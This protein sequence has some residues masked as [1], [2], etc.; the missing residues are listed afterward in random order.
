M[1]NTPKSDP[2][3]L[4]KNNPTKDG[5]Y[6]PDW[7][8][9]A[10]EAIRSQEAVADAIENHS[11]SLGLKEFYKNLPLN[12]RVKF[13]KFLTQAG[14]TWDNFIIEKGARSH[15]ALIKYSN[16]KEIAMG[17]DSISIKDSKRMIYFPGT[18]RI[19]DEAPTLEQ[20]LR[21]FYV[22]NNDPEAT[23]QLTE[24]ESRI[25][26]AWAEEFLELGDGKL[27]HEAFDNFFSLSDLIRWNIVKK[28]QQLYQNQDPYLRNITAQN[29]WIIIQDGKKLFTVWEG[30]GFNFGK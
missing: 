15:I 23:K 30:R 24:L 28:I 6:S 29:L 10:L 1:V 7:N 17:I 26:Q 12:E 18:K 8:K 11:Q 22:V 19:P 20:Y 5:G 25:S 13:I 9:Q 14:V 21:F 2:E 16:W 3:M 27:F 4:K